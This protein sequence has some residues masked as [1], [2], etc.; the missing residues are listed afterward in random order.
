MFGH[1]GRKLRILAVVIFCIGAAAGVLFSVD[2]IITTGDFGRSSLDI[3]HCILI[4]LI[5]VLIAWAGS[6]ALYALGEMAENS[7]A[8]TKLLKELAEEMR[9]KRKD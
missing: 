2:F 5:T 8:Q 7:A 6:F 9:G 4:V 1:I 3:L